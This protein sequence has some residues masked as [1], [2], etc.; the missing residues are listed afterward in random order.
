MSSG[1]K[2]SESG[3]RTIIAAD[4]H[5]R[6]DE[7]ARGAFAALLELARASRAPLYILGDL[8]HYWLGPKHLRHPMYS[9]ELDLLRG[10]TTGG[11]R[12][13]VVPGNRDYLLDA[14]FRRETDVQ[15]LGD[16]AVLELENERIHLSHGDLFAT[17]DVRYLRM[18][19][20]L[21]SRM[22]RFLARTM[23]SWLVN[24]VARRLR[25]HSQHA[26]AGKPVRVLQPDRGAVSALFREGF[27]T[28][29]CGHF[30]RHRDESFPAAEGGGRFII[31][32][33]FEERG[34]CLVHDGSG[35]ESRRLGARESSVSA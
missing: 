29:I 31:L 13:L 28:V 9:R 8:F 20:I 7:A 3:I 24:L 10:A 2:S 5:L 30:H 34:F 32:E 23:P 27:A 22:L 35:W 6:G 4:L 11:A 21:R 15:V 26:V 19:R 12:I 17:S 25:G 33:P 1:T 18:R 14:T 16:D